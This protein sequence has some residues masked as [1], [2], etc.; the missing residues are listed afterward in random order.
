MELSPK[1]K[2]LPVTEEVTD[3]AV[4]PAPPLPPS[5]MVMAPL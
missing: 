3:P 2:M 4:P 5:P 1:V